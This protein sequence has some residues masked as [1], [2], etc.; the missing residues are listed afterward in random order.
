M[1]GA[2]IRSS[3]Q[4]N[5]SLLVAGRIIDRHMEN[6]LLRRILSSGTHMQQRA[7]ASNAEPEEAVSC[8]LDAPGLLLLADIANQGGLQMPESSSAEAQRE[9][10]RPQR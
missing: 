9:G 1:W 2:R 8:C 6:A 10:G 4:P 7:Q 5:K 3:V